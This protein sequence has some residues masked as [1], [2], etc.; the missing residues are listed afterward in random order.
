[1]SR[2]KS[3]VNRCC[4]SRWYSALP[5]IE[6]HDGSYG[7]DN[8]CLARTPE[9]QEA[10]F[11]LSTPSGQRAFLSRWCGCPTSMLRTTPIWYAKE[12]HSPDAYTSSCPS[13][14][15][16]LHNLDHYHNALHRRCGCHVSF[17]IASIAYH[18]FVV[19][20]SWL[21]FGTTTCDAMNGKNHYR[22]HSFLHSLNKCELINKNDSR[23]TIWGDS[24][25]RLETCRVMLWISCLF[26]YALRVIDWNYDKSPNFFV[27]LLIRS[28]VL[29]YVLIYC[30]HAWRWKLKEG[31][32][33]SW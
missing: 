17:E 6:H 5:C 4:V 3:V 15:R 28:R 33:R 7:L 12:D 25:A 1:M 2:I 32:N 11:Y 8:R 21:C 18:G 27:E 14:L 19:L 29:S 24:W 13:P 30:K 26:L 9:R 10:S 22:L 23:G 16:V 20:L 31:R